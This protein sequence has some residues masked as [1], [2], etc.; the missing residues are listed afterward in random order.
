MLPFIKNNL[1]DKNIL[2]LL[3]VVGLIV[4]F[5]RIDFYSGILNAIGNILGAGFK[6]L[7]DQVT[8]SSET[9]YGMNIG[10]I[11]KIILFLTIIMYYNS[12]KN[13]SVIAVN[14]CLIYLL[15][16]FYFSTSQSFINRFS[17][18][19]FWG[20]ILVYIDL[21]SIIRRRKHYLL[22]FA[23]VLGFIFARTYLSYNDVIYKYSNRLL[24]EDN[25]YERTNN[26]N[27]H[28]QKR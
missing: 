8:S 26:R 13:I 2:L 4:Y 5:L 21:L 27:N 7:T 12:V 17:N 20:Y 1:F 9:E 25:K 19:F 10:I 23:Y 11:E 28:Y 14:C 16:Y 22:Y 24:E 18:L 15:I 6:S 3:F